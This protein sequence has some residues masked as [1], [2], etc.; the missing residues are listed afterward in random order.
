M[1]W[2]NMAAAHIA[3]R[4]PL[5][6]PLL[7]VSTAGAPSLDAIGVAARMVEAGQVDVAILGVDLTPP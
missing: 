2:P 7:T 6:G 5:H 3:L 4:D 1:A